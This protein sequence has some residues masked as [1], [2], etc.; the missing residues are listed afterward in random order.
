[1]FFYFCF[2]SDVVCRLF[3]VINLNSFSGISGSSPIYLLVTPDVRLI[4]G[5]DSVETIE[6]KQEMMR[7][8]EVDQ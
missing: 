1:M 4:R 3:F 7:Y 2:T 6:I 8:I 5:K